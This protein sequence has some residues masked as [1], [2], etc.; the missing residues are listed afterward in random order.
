MP[1]G[2]FTGCPP[3]SIELDEKCYRSTIFTNQ[4]VAIGL[5]GFN[6]EVVDDIDIYNYARSN[7]GFK[8]LP[9]NHYYFL[10]VQLTYTV[11]FQFYWTTAAPSVYAS[12]TFYRYEDGYG[13]PV[14][15]VNE[16]EPLQVTNPAIRYHMVSLSKN[17]LT[18]LSIILTLLA[19]LST[20]GQPK[21]P[22]ET[23]GGETAVHFAQC[24]ANQT[25]SNPE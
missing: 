1:P 17:H 6:E 14:F 4:T 5:C 3:G 24:F 13:D 21:T 20:N 16:T 10:S 8:V 12:E 22:M 19:V 9:L 7:G 18:S 23:S 11:H 2:C 15:R 25:V